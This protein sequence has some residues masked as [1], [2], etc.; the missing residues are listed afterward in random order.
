MVKSFVWIG[1]VR[2]ES[3]TAGLVNCRLVF[4]AMLADAVKAV[5]AG[6]AWCLGD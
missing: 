3:I 2:P 1:G 6:D 4:P 5:E